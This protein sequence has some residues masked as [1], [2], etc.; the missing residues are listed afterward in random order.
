MTDKIVELTPD[1]ISTSDFDRLEKRLKAF[2]RREI[3]KPALKELGEPKDVLKN[4]EE[5]EYRALQDGLYSGRITFYRGVF[6][7]KFNA[8]IS[9]ELRSLGAVWDRK[10]S[11][12]RIQG[13]ALP[14]PVRSLISA[15]ESKFKRVLDRIDDKLAKILPEE[16]SSKFKCADIFESTLYKSDQAFRQAVKSVA[17]QPQLPAEQRKKIADEWQ[18]N[19]ELWIKDFTKKEIKQLRTDLQE[20]VFAGNRYGNAVKTIQKSYGVS[21]RKA[22]FLARQETSLLMAKFQE[23]QYQ[24][25][26]I[27]EYKWGTVA[28]SKL[29]PVRPSHKALE[30]KIFRWDDPPITTPAGEPARRNNPGQDYN[31]RCFA[32]PI[33]RVR[34]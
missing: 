18:N 30:G 34:K 27:K 17:I 12:Y 9:K 8:G 29:H 20:S 5:S 4:S 15:S 32:K 10:T 33:V 22:K 2:F 3:Y 11:T 26:G 28:G 21:E 25:A 23:T 19:M 31:C 6:S 24:D 14:M 13:S 16:I 7:G 1:K